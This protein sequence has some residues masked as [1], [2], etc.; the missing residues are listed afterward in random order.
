MLTCL[1]D[2]V[3]TVYQ[4]IILPLFH[5]KPGKTC[6]HVL[7]CSVRKLYSPRRCSKQT[8]FVFSRGKQVIQV[9][10]DN[11][12]SQNCKWYG[13]WLQY[14]LVLL[15]YKCL[16]LNIG[17]VNFWSFIFKVFNRILHP[18]LFFQLSTIRKNLNTCN[19]NWKKAGN[20]SF[21]VRI[22]NVY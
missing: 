21:L 12:W 4:C 16:E 11:K 6:A 9:C 14:V 20:I 8:C 2:L 18:H 15:F 17:N 13:K 19:V 10:D 5:Y 7:W 3:N 22:S 1:S